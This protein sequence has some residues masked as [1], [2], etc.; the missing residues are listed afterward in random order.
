VTAVLLAFCA[1]LGLIVGSF[2]NVVIWRVPR[3]ES[4]VSP[5][6]HCPGC[7]A[8]I[9]PRDNIPVVSWLL[10]RGRCRD[11]GT[12][13][14][15]RYPAVEL[16]TGAVF[17]AVAWRVGVDLAQYIALVAFL[18]LAAVG[19]AQALID[20]DTRRLPFRV[21]NVAWVTGLVVL[22]AATLADGHWWP[23]IRALIGMAAL[24]EL[25][26]VLAFLRPRDMGQGDVHLAGPLGLFLGWLGW[27]SL[28]VGAFLGFFIGGLGGLALIAARR[29]GMKSKIPYGPYMLA[30]ALVAI[31]F[32]QQLG[33]LYV[34][35]T[36]G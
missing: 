11:C 34:D 17:V 26:D 6:S 36:I 32:G 1:L 22:L 24:Y 35:L 27:S 16:L 29:A 33:G 8:P 31:L 15:A 13:I 10:L 12:P 3:D 2:L 9:R 5:P 18:V 23:Y 21:T 20:F 7:A 14:S 4:V 28:A 25:Y 30:G 19:V